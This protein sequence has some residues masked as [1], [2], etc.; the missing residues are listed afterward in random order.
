MEWKVY[1]LEFRTLS[2]PTSAS[3]DIVMI[4]IDD[5]SI[6]NMDQALN[7]GRFPWPR[8]VYTYLL[9]YLSR[10]RPQ[11]VVFDVLFLEEDKSEGGKD[12][13]DGFAEATRRLGCV[14]Q[15]IDVNDTF[16]LQPGFLHA[17]GYRL[18]REVEEHR[19]IKLPYERLARASR[20]LGST[21][22]VLD[23]DGPVRRHVP[24]VR[25]GDALYPSLAIATAMVSLKLRPE[26]VWTDAGGLHLGERLIPLIDVHPE[27]ASRIE[28]RHMLVNYRGAAFAD[29]ER[30][31]TTYRSYHF[32]DV[33]ESELRIEAGKEPKFDPQLFRDK[34]VFIGT[35]A[36]GLMDIFQTPFG[37]EG[38]M[39]GMQIH[40][41]VVDDI[42]AR[43]FMRP[44]RSAW[45]VTLLGASTLVVGTLGVYVGFWWALA[46]ALMVGFS[47]AGVAAVSFR[48]GIW[49]PCVPTVV[50]LLVA[51]F[52]SV[53]YKYFVEDKAKRQVK[54]LF[55]RYV[56]PVVVKELIDDPSK[57]KLG[58]QRRRMTVLFS[59][60][61]GFTTLSEAGKP[62][63]IIRQ[64][65]EYFSRMV[66]LLF[67]HHGTLDK[68]VGDM[69]MGLFN[70]PVLDTDHADHAVQMGLAMLEGLKTLNERWRGEGRPTFDI[71][72][73][74]NTGDMIV[75]NVGSEKTLSYTV[76]GDNVNL[77]SRLE[78]LNKQFNS[79]I[80]ISEM[81]KSMLKGS[82]H[83]R[84]LG[85]V[86]VKGKTKEV[87]I[88]E[89]CV[90]AEEL[91]A[92]EAAQENT[93]AVH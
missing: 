66:D 84:P 47:C 25:Q 86:K 72:V 71:G 43:S 18:G 9:N 40:A 14:V 7:I 53:A 17:S 48:S 3:R 13:D 4:K 58:G 64:L 82:Y 80:I 22:M 91:K 92:K 62:E 28:T 30:K 55:S 75:G 5:V 74:I 67:Q 26:N 78:S 21:F 50:G 54:A 45:M 32:C 81:T 90:S 41:S 39:P 93:S 87:S 33:F 35:T 46:A 38:K 15:A 6:Q 65:N 8:D 11:A 89:V 10:A 85:S 44:A 12:R 56:S 1:D 51:Q 42:L 16:D 27:Y 23:A 37:S 69:I 20:M 31:V 79:H 52:S 61:R 76:I 88:Y 29:G 83:M 77:G 49:L 60:I 19:S 70:A 24:F 34:I 63:D 36:A 57:A 2:N 68:F 59:D 73:G